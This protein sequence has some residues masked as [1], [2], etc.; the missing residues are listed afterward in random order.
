MP[1][2]LFLC[3]ANSARSQMAEGLA[4]E[5]FGAHFDILSAGS[6]PTFVNPFAIE[7]MDEIGIDISS[8]SSNLV[9]DVDLTKVDSVI[10]LCADEICP[11][12]SLKLSQHHWPFP[13]P[14]SDDP[15]LSREQQLT[16]FRAIRAKIR[17][18]L[19]IELPKLLRSG[20]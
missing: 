13:D 15:N 1:T 11:V 20:D 19:E 8:H 17:S 18:V 4:R 3:V 7:V 6:A 9:D 5:L 16:N 14:A 10:T 2:I 12:T